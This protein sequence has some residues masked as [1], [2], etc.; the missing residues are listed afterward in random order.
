MIVEINVM[1]ILTTIPDVV[2]VIMKYVSL[3]AIANIPRFYYASLTSEHMLVK[4][5]DMKLP[6]TKY[7]TKSKVFETTK[8][9]FS[10]LLLRFINKFWR[11]IYACWSYYF[12]P[13]TAVFLN[14]S[15]MITKCKCWGDD[16]L[17]ISPAFPDCPRE[18][19]PKCLEIELEYNLTLSA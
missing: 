3:A 16:P 2:T 1:L 5:K 12:M 8:L 6:I 10:L 11:L 19:H 7:R 4:V 13:F 14:A 15:F 18:D 17:K 9:S